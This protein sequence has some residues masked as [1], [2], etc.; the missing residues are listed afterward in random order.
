KGTAGTSSGMSPVSLSEDSLGDRVKSRFPG[1]HVISVAI[2]DRAAILMGGRRADAAYWLDWKSGFISSSYY[3]YDPTLFDGNN[4]LFA[5]YAPQSRTWTLSGFI[6]DAD[7][8]RV[9][10]DPPEA[11]KLKNPKYG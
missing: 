9:T 8:E 10:F 1:S 4:D 3:R 2:K 5:R 11:A 7:L 6:P